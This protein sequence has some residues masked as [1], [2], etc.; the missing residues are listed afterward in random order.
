MKRLSLIIC[1]LFVALFSNAQYLDSTMI[2]V[3]NYSWTAGSTSGGE[4]YELTIHQDTVINDTAYYIIHKSGIESQIFIDVVYP[5]TTPPPPQFG[6]INQDVGFLREEAGTFILRGSPE[7]LLYDFTIEIGDSVGNLEVMNIDTVQ[8]FGEERKRFLLGTVNVIYPFYMI[9]GVGHGI[10]GFL[11]PGVQGVEYG[12]IISCVKK[13]VGNQ[14]FV[15]NPYDS[16]SCD[17]LSNYVYPYE[18]PCVPYEDSVH[19]NASENS[20]FIFNGDTTG[21]L[22]F[23]DTGM[24]TVFLFDSISG[25]GY[26]IQFDVS[27]Y[28]PPTLDLVVSSDSLICPGDSLWLCGHPGYADYL[29]STG[30]TVECELFTFESC[31]EG[32]IVLQA[33]DAN[34]CIIDYDPFTIHCGDSVFADFSWDYA[35]QDIGFTN[36]SINAT[37]YLWDFGDGFSSND[38]NPSHNFGNGTFEVCLI[39]QNECMADTTCQTIIISSVPESIADVLGIEFYTSTD[40]LII[41]SKFER[42][43]EVKVFDS[44][45]RMVSIESVGQNACRLNIRGLNNAMYLLKVKLVSGKEF[46]GKFLR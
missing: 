38:E 4:H 10:G 28:Q 13:G 15:M 37:E 19:I 20:G 41:D 23:T 27:P 7:Y 21:T 33:V 29:W 1:F 35:L 25:E 9:E 6:V 8:F 36:S 22:F 12:T 18:I 11:S 44:V 5:L 46:S 42:I 16:T 17:I 24:H 3:E 39:A 32:P 45:G 30:S 2:W 14:E 40:R 31:W 43:A 26:S 34:G